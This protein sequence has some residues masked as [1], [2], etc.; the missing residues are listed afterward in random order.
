MSENVDYSELRPLV[1]A[2]VGFAQDYPE[3]LQ[4]AIVQAL[5]SQASRR[6]G[7][8]TGTGEPQG[9][10]ALGDTG[11]AAR[12]TANGGRSIARLAEE[13][14]A[15]T[16]AVRRVVDIDGE[17]G[18]HVLIRVEGNNNSELQNR[19]AAVYCFAREK[20]FGELDTPID[21][22]RDLCQERRCYDS[23]NFTRNFRTGDYLREIGGRG[24]RNKRYRLSAEGEAEARRVFAEHLP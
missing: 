13:L 2:A 5:L 22:L 6:A 14:A 15:D 7:P 16:S 8:V 18:L 21:E 17:G 19:Y 23:A 3:Q 9:E 4:P 11:A 20:A 1:D 10:L 12:Q 24:S